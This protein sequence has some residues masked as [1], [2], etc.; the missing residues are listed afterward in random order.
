M[1]DLIS[2]SELIEIIKG[3][4]ELLNFQKDECI[5]CINAC[6][7]AYDIDK[8]VEEL[9]QL[10]NKGSVTKSEKLITNACVN[11]AIE[12][13][14]QG[15]VETNQNRDNSKFTDEDLDKIWD[16]ILVDDCCEWESDYKFISDKYKRETS[17]GY[18]F[19]DL[20]HAVPF[21]YC[22][23]CSKKIKVVE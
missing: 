19:Y 22:P 15:G 7:I 17:C 3:T 6:D 5:I 2:K 21:K 4:E 14:K 10:K 9:E 12:I 13:V 8:V 18:T 23:Y 1:N 11:K 16:K 20:H